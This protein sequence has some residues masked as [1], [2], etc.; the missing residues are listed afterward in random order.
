MPDKADTPL[1][2][3][4]I[5]REIRLGRLP[6]PPVAE[7]FDFTIVELEKGRIVLET[8]P[9]AHMLNPSGAITGGYAATLLDSVCGLA[10]QSA[11]SSGQGYTTLELKVAFHRS[12]SVESGPVRTRG[13]IVSIG[14]RV[15]FTSAELHDREGRLCASAT[16][17]L[18]ILQS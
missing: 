8:R 5:L 11:L 14:R 7:T 3:L 1:D 18:L 4:G 2:G 10:V 9:P 12:L 17:T 6:R 13:E 15:A 16:S